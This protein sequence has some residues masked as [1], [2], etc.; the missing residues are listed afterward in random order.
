[1]GVV[2]RAG[3]ERRLERRKRDSSLAGKI[4]FRLAA[5]VDEETLL[6]VERNLICAEEITHV[7]QGRPV[8]ESKLLLAIGGVAQANAS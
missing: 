4:G 5:I 2:C 7:G 3:Q 1:M 8:G 6:H